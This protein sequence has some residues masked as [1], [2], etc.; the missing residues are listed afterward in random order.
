MTYYCSEKIAAIKNPS[1][2]VTEQLLNNCEQYASYNYGHGFLVFLLFL[3][4]MQ[5]IVHYTSLISTRQLMC[6]ALRVSKKL[7]VNLLHLIDLQNICQVT[8][9]SFTKYDFFKYSAMQFLTF[10]YHQI[11]EDRIKFKISRNLKY[12]LTMIFRNS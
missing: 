3:F 8:I 10:I 1:F 9:D 6:Y 11:H 7:R 5:R 4:I 12:E 2:S